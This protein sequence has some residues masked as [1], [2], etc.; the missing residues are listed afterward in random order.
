[1]KTR[2]QTVEDIRQKILSTTAFA[3]QGM[4][5]AGPKETDLKLKMS[6]LRAA[7]KVYRKDALQIEILNDSVTLEFSKEATIGLLAGDDMCVKTEVHIEELGEV[8]R[9]K[10]EKLQGIFHEQALARGVPKKAIDEYM[11]QFAYRIKDLVS[12]M[13][14]CENCTGG[15]ECKAH[16]LKNEKQM[17]NVERAAYRVN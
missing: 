10:S 2:A 13:S 11:G 5:L 16:V 4:Q 15:L 12:S 1:M 3:T 8:W 17:V 6:D 7:D 14:L 9:G